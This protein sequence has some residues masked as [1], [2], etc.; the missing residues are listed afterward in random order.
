M[1]FNCPNNFLKG[2]YSSIESDANFL[3]TSRKKSL[4][5]KRNQGNYKNSHGRKGCQRLPTLGKR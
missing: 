4:P 2:K 5:F 3:S 1:R